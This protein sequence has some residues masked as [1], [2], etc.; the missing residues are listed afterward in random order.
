MYRAA[1]TTGILVAGS[2]GI[3]DLDES[4]GLRS[5]YDQVQEKRLTRE[6]PLCSAAMHFF[7]ERAF[8]VSVLQKEACELVMTLIIGQVG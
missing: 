5:I 2:L 3:N 4:G 7:F 6:L 8:D 1:Y